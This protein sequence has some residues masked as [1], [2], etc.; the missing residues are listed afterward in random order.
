M[1]P[2]VGISSKPLGRFEGGNASSPEWLSVSIASLTVRFRSGASIEAPGGAGSLVFMRRRR[3]GTTGSSSLLSAPSSEIST[4]SG[5]SSVIIGSGW[6]GSF[7]VSFETPDAARA[8]RVME[9]GVVDFSDGMAEA[10]V[11]VLPVDIF[12]DSIESGLTY[13]GVLVTLESARCN[14]VTN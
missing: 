6:D 14:T 8:V 5:S 13:G 12:E 1:T 3:L 7:G 11:W 2:M 4:K 10:G 9:D